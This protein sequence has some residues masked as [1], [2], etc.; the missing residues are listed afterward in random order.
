MGVSTIINTDVGL[1]ILS[2]I[3]EILF[4][5]LHYFDQRHV[6]IIEQVELWSP[7]L[8]YFTSPGIDTR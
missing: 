2:I 7:V 5:P 4:T 3:W 8:G 6:D 1:S